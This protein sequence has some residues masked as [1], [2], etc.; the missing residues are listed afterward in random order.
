MPRPW[1]D[2]SFGLIGIA[3][4]SP[5]PTF[6]E[7]FMKVKLTVDI[8][9]REDCI[10]ILVQLLQE[11]PNHEP[12]IN[13]GQSCWRVCS[14]WLQTWAVTGN[15]KVRLFMQRNE[16]HS[17][18]LV[19][20]ITVART[21][22]PVT[23]RPSGKTD[24]VEELHFGDVGYHLA[25]HF[26]SGRATRETLQRWLAWLG[27]VWDDRDSLRLV[28]DCHSVSRQERMKRCAAELGLHL[29]FISPGPTHEMQPL[30][31]FV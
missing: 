1:A 22:L 3:I 10:Y 12:R 9:S 27:S 25:D 23:I 24:A 17:F 19:S 20:A 6:L 28:L 15:Q 18:T 16:K 5:N 4:I 13:L 26:E 29:L 8:E 31:R 7:L 21:E 2:I 14:E 30:D 11:I